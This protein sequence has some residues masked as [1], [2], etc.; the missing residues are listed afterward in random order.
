MERDSHTDSLSLAS[1]ASKRAAVNAPTGHNGTTSSST[2]KRYPLTTLEVFEL[3]GVDM[4]YTS[5]RT[6]PMPFLPGVRMKIKVSSA[7]YSTV[8][9]EDGGTA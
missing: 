5:D 7:G 6:G 1:A 2:A 4:I 9:F 8:S 3:C